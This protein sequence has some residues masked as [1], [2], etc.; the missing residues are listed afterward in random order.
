[1]AGRGG[2]G[3][4]GVDCEAHWGAAG[5]ALAPSLLPSCSLG[6]GFILDYWE[7]AWVPSL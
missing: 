7:G 2:R 4:S 5:L 1:M 3:D 6:G